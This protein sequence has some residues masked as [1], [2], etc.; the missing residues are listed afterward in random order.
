MEISAPFLKVTSVGAALISGKWDGPIAEWQ[1]CEALQT[2]HEADGWQIH[3]IK[4]QE[5][6]CHAVYAVGSKEG[7]S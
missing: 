7:N 4:D 3:S 2:E 6:G 1:P 5:D